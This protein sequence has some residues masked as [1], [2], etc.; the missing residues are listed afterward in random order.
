M[1]TTRFRSQHR[2][3]CLYL[4]SP[5]RQ[6]E[7]MEVKHSGGLKCQ[8][9]EG[10]F[11]T[12]DARLAQRLRTHAAHG[13]TFHELPIEQPTESDGNGKKASGKAAASAA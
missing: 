3:F 9:T 13:V 10:Q 7:G 12:D 2:N 5:R 1:S 6:V 4:D 11:A 8:F